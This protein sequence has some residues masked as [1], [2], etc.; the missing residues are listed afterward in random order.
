MT[1][2][3]FSFRGSAPGPRW[4]LCPPTPTIQKKSP[5]LDLYVAQQHVTFKLF[6]FLSTEENWEPKRMLLPCPVPMYTPTPVAMYSTPAPYPIL[7]P[8]PIP[9]PCFIP[10]S[11]KTSKSI[12]KKIKVSYALDD[13][14]CVILFVIKVLALVAVSKGTRAVKEILQFLTRDAGYEDCPV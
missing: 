2:N 12:Y 14:Q 1:K 11:R 5:P 13:A 9:V 6:T 7:V 4:G 10:T 8:V 3:A